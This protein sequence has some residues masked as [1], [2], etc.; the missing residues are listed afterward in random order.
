M[1]PLATQIQNRFQADGLPKVYVPKDFLDLGTREAVDQ[2]LTRLV[3]AERLAR[4]GGGLYS[5]PQQNR[6][7]AIPIVPDPDE[8]A[9]ALARQTG[10][11]IAPSGAT[12][13][14]RL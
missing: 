1:D 7:V 11:R 2:A 4:L 6:R 10:A 13:A 12:A 8:I 3:R 5:L 14:N 9:D